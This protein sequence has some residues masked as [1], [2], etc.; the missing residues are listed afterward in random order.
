MGWETHTLLAELARREGVSQ[1]EVLAFLVRR[2]AY[3]QHLIGKKYDDAQMRY[4]QRLR[5]KAERRPKRRRFEEFEPSGNGKRQG[6]TTCSGRPARLP[7]CVA[8]DETLDS[9][10]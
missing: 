2:H 3:G 7:Q 1:G 8:F 9:G 10:E 5:E 6:D 4:A